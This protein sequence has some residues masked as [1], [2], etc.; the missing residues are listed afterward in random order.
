MRS[1]YQQL[2]AAYR[3]A[4]D[5]PDLKRIAK[6]HGE[7]LLYLVGYNKAAGLAAIE[8]YIYHYKRFSGEAMGNSEF[9]RRSKQLFI[10]SV[11]AKVEAP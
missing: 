11:I 5:I 4:I 3:A 7:A 1:D 2:A 9:M 8:V 10:D 6:A